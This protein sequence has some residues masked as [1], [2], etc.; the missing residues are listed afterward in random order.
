MVVDGKV[1]VETK[2]TSNLHPV[3]H[4][5]LYSYLRNTHFEVGLL[6]HFGREPTFYR[7]VSSNSWPSG[8][9]CDLED[10]ERSTVE[11]LNRRPLPDPAV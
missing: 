2:S 10:E 5:Q 1:I 6:F 9:P 8:R 7:L 3:A 11:R 4:R